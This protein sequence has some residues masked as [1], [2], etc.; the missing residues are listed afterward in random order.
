[1]GCVPKSALVNNEASKDKFGAWRVKEII[2]D[3]TVIF[4]ATK[5]AVVRRSF[6]GFFI[7]APN[8]IE[9]IIPWLT[10]YNQGLTVGPVGIR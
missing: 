1:V 8:T 3:H 4:E 9:G 10:T 6:S 5:E 7:T 2:G